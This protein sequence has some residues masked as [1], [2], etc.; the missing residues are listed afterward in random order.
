MYCVLLRIA[1]ELSYYK[2]KERKQA[3]LKY[4]QRDVNMAPMYSL[5]PK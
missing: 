3:T 2:G 1:N 5:D 4:G